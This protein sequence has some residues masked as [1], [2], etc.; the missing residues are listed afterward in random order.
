[1]LPRSASLCVCLILWGCSD[2]AA[3]GGA[4]GGAPT[5]GN[6]T[7]G[8]AVGAGSQGGA[9]DGGAGPTGGAASGGGTS[10]GGAPSC[11]GKTLGAGDTDFS[12]DFDGATREYRVH[13]PPGYDPAVGAPVVLVFHGYLESNDDIENIT[14]M[15]PE[16]DA[17]GYIAVYPQGLSTSW[18]AGNCCGSS[19]QLGVDDVGFVNEMLD[20]IE[21]DYCVDID[22]VFSAGFSN[23]GI[24]SHRLACEMADRIAAIGPV[25]GPI[26]VEPCTPS[27]PVP[28]QHFHGTSDFVVPYN[29]G[30]FTGFTSV[31]DSI[32]GWVERNGCATTPTVSFDMGD[33]TCE[34]YSS[35]TEN[36]DVILCTLEGGGHQW[37]G[38]ESAGPG[39]TINMDI[40]ASEA[41]LDFFDAH[42]MP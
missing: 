31:A 9:A 2:D 4:G 18:N 8:E 19:Q 35:C 20:R 13:A 26:G 41:L 23:G 29:G 33:A 16:A 30:G 25:S 21:A 6:N 14:Q 37:P 3:P 10:Q 36:A 28:V 22:R 17:R 12:F 11:G 1:M 15:T 38:G 24:L 32:A 7:G 42:P 39:G 5:A 34:T 27:R 40:F